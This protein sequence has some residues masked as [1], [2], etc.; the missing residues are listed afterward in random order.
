MTEPTN[1]STPRTREW[2]QRQRSCGLVQVNTW[3]PREYAQPL[4]KIFNMLGDPDWR[5]SALRSVVAHWLWRR[6]PV[7]SRLLGNDGYT[8]EIDAPEVDD[9]RELIPI[10][11]R[12]SSPHTFVELTPREAADLKRDLQEAVAQVA[13]NFITG[14]DLDKNLRDRTGV[15]L[16]DVAPHHTGQRPSDLKVYDV[17][18]PESTAQFEAREAAVMSSIFDTPD[19]VAIEEID[20]G[21]YELCYE[22]GT[23]MPSRAL[24]FFGKPGELDRTIDGIIALIG[25]PGRGTPPALVFAQLTK[26]VRKNLLADIGDAPMR[27][28]DVE[29]DEFSV[30]GALRVS[31]VKSDKDLTALEWVSNPEISEALKGAFLKSLTLY[32]EWRERGRLKLEDAE[33]L[34][35][36]GDGGAPA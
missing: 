33:A 30:K 1:V 22:G 16:L 18:R 7:A 35:S 9:G 21:L 17:D 15:L 3:V 5:G 13:S 29:P 25:L 34:A 28:L 6:R 14:R 26:A 19:K 8:I 11:G 12:I 23:G 36:L 2:R 24:L 27:Y 4:R 20:D 10:G 32:R 31:E